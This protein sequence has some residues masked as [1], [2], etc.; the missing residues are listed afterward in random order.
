MIQLAAFLP[1]SP[2]P[3]TDIH[4]MDLDQD[5]AHALIYGLANGRVSQ[6]Q[7]ATMAS[8]VAKVSSEGVVGV[9]HT[10]VLAEP[11]G[12]TG[13]AR[14]LTRSPAGRHRVSFGPFKGVTVRHRA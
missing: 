4:G 7:I 14:S 13:R 1:T 12:R 9:G 3:H 6:Q 5:Q 10:I 8:V 11:A 2:A